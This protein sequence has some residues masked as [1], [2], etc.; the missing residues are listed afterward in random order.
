MPGRDFLVFRLHGPMSAFGDIVVGERRSIWNEPSKSAVLGFAAG[1]LGLE[2]EQDENHQDLE[3]GLGFAVRVD[4]PGLPLRDYHTAQAPK[5][6]KDAKWR[7][8]RDELAD[9]DELATVLSERIYRLEA[10]ATAILWRKADIGPSL[11]A[12]RSALLRPCFTPFL[13]RKACPLGLPV[14]PEIVEAEGLLAALDLYDRRRAEME[15]GLDRLMGRAAVLRPAKAHVWFEM[16]AGLQGEEGAADL[17]RQ[18]RDSVR[19]RSPRQF[20]DRMEGRLNW[21]PNMLESIVA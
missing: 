16:D 12:L 11:D 10:W 8:R 19:Q 20:A 2:R 17:I 14:A 9:K 4:A 7:T 15:Q 1:A 21:T 5:A 3:A 18:R 13:G 6:R